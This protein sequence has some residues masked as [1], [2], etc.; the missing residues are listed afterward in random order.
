MVLFGIKLDDI[1]CVI[2]PGSPLAMELPLIESNNVVLP[3]STFSVDPLG[4]QCPSMTT[5]GER[6]FML[7]PLYNFAQAYLWFFCLLQWFIN[8]TV[9]YS[10]TSKVQM[11]RLL[12]LLIPPLAGCANLDQPPEEAA[13]E[14]FAKGPERT[15]GY[16]DLALKTRYMGRA[17]FDAENKAAAQAELCL[18]PE[19]LEIAGI[20]VSGLGGSVWASYNLADLE[21]TEVDVNLNYKGKIT[22][23]LTYKIGGAVYTFPGIG[24]PDARE[25]KGEMT[26]NIP[27]EFGVFK[28]G[29]YGAAADYGDG[30]G[31]YLEAFA[32]QEF[33][34]LGVPLV[35]DGRL[36]FNDKY[37]TDKSGL[38]H[39]SFGLTVPIKLSETVTARIS[40]RGQKA[41]RK[42]FNSGVWVGGGLNIKF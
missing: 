38:S 10:K 32:S 9:L 18:R 42:E 15:I 7:S 19:N 11:K 34:S 14:Q 6:I 23:N 16:V 36:G 40:A 22:D 39:T 20:D 35:V 4:I 31:Y 25:F 30:N 13:R 26:A 1:T 29:L 3:W 28:P 12:Y 27:W 33:S 21:T 5:I 2:S 17:G 41:I 8:I 24:I 37:F